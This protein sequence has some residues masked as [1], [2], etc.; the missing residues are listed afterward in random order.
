MC[1]GKRNAILNN[2]FGRS[3]RSVNFPK[4]TEERDRAASVTLNT[5]S[6]QAQR[7]P[8]SAEILHSGCASCEQGL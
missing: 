3:C 2:E 1:L 5:E 4:F 8:H 6:I 7:F